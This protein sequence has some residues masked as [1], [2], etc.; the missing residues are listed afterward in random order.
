MSCRLTITTFV[1]LFLSQCAVSGQG[2]HTRSNRALKY[3]DLGK[4]DYDL[5]FLDRAERNLKVAIG[6][7]DKFYEAHLLLGQLYSD[8]GEWEKSVTHYRKAVSLD[9]LYFIPALYSLGRAE[10]RTGRY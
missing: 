9:S 5:L 10:M 2:L 3:Y 4:R 8:I 7:D 1:F 6:E